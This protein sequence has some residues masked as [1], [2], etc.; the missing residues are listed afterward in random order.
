[1]PSNGKNG[2]QKG[3]FWVIKVWWQSKINFLATRLQA[4]DRVAAVAQPDYTF[5][6]SEGKVTFL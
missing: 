6:R 3:A 5:F 1:M 2:Q 4:M